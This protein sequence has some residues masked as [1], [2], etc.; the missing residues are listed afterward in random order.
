M[1]KPQYHRLERRY[2]ATR[3]DHPR[4]RENIARLLAGEESVG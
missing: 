4:A 2:R 3:R 1:S